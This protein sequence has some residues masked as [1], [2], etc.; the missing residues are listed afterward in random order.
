MQL[1]NYLDRRETFRAKFQ[2]KSTIFSKLFM[3][4][5]SLFFMYLDL[6]MV[7]KKKKKVWVLVVT[8]QY[9]SK[10]KHEKLLMQLFRK[11]IID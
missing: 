7:T 9:S 10:N 4:D 8:H 6:I 2:L 1:G 3:R 5:E 11:S